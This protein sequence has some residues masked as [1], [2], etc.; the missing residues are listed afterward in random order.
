MPSSPAK[1]P[2]Q[3]RQTLEQLQELQR[4]TGNAILRSLDGEDRMQTT[5]TDGRPTADVADTFIKPN[6]RLTAFER[7]EIYNRQYWYRL[8]DSMYEDFPGL[9]AILGSEK[10]NPL[11]RAY[12]AKYPSRSF[13]LRNLGSRMPRF[14]VEEPEWAAPH[15]EMA[16]DM[17]RFEWA[18]VV[19]F[20]EGAKR[21]LVAD[22]LL[23]RDPEKLRLGLQPYITL[24]EMAYPLDDFSL[25]L[26]KQGAA[27]RSEAS[28][29][30][31]ES[32]HAAPTRHI[33]RPRRKKTFV[34]VHRVD[35]DLYYRSLEPAAFKLLQALSQGRPLAQ[36]CELVAKE[37]TPHA[38]NKWFT[39]W[40]G[41]GWFCKP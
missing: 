30:M 18:Q 1:R 5:W 28:N 6:D 8:I 21:P 13:T 10:F 27:L 9:L 26:K 34:A 25:A 23:G 22:D 36:A 17:A 31:D 20:D 29:A 35:N 39:N 33:P 2:G 32:D 40:A 14:L 24:L 37:A 12:L 16:Q 3:K 15:E 7:L 19:A 4:L 11:I 41:L 38:I